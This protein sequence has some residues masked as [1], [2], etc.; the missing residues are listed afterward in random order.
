MR[1]ATTGTSTPPPPDSASVP[2]SA[3]AIIIA[4]TEPLIN[5]WLRV[6]HRKGRILG[7]GG[8]GGGNTFEA[9]GLPPAAFSLIDGER[10]SS[11]AHS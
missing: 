1:I 4:L 7:E 5:G 8:Q 2:E 9:L 11:P 10:V 6:P 3:T